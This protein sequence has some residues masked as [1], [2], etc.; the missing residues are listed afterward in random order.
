[1][2]DPTNDRVEFVNIHGR[3]E[4][5][6]VLFEKVRCPPFW[7]N[8]I[9]SVSDCWKLSILE[10]EKAG[11]KL[12]ERGNI[13]K[14]AKTSKYETEEKNETSREYFENEL[15]EKVADNCEPDRAAIKG[16]IEHVFGDEDESVPV[17]CDPKEHDYGWIL[18][19]GKFYGCE[20]HGHAILAKRLLKQESDKEHENPED[21]AEKRGWIKITK[22]AIDGKYMMFS[23]KAPNKNQEKTLI[24][25]SIPRGVDYK[26]LQILL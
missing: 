2:N 4:T 5:L 21:E 3:N 18:R 26:E 15:I 23:R 22:S 11:I 10:Y 12:Q 9:S 7:I 1:M 13:C 8:T 25:W 16:T 19:D 24:D 20:Y 17:A 14:F 6:A